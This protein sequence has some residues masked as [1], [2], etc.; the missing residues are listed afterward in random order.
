MAAQ[1][2]VR[3]T[4]EFV[5]RGELNFDSVVSLWQQAAQRFGEQP[6]LRID[7][8]QVKRSDSSGVALLVTWLQQAK[9]RRQDLQFVNVPPQMLSIIEVADLD[10]LLPLA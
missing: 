2:E 7:L 4:G 8:A 10:K 1:L 3:D 5:I 9:A 6:S